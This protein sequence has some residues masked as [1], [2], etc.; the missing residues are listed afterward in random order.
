MKL[1]GR[2]V[3]RDELQADKR[4][5]LLH[6]MQRHYENV[7]PESSHPDVGFYVVQKEYP[8]DCRSVGI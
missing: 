3:S 1:D 8:R 5:E 6:P 4:T 7:V 2:L